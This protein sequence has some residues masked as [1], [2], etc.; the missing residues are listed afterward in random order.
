MRCFSCRS[1]W[2]NSTAG[3]QHCFSVRSIDWGRLSD[4]C[5]YLDDLNTVLVPELMPDL[6][7]KPNNKCN[8]GPG[9]QADEVGEFYFMHR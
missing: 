7:R 8:P 4:V 9:R 5:R 1:W 6:P 3:R 2:L